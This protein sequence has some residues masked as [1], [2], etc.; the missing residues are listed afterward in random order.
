MWSRYATAQAFC[1]WTKSTH[2]L[3][4]LQQ[5]V[6]SVPFSIASLTDE[7]KIGDKIYKMINALEQSRRKLRSIAR[8]EL[9]GI[10]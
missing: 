8:K 10:M 1:A 3:G 4:V 2:F 7:M 6:L 9:K 5:P